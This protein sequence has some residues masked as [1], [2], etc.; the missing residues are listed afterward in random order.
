VNVIPDQRAV[1][2][3]V[4]KRTLAETEAPASQVQDTDKRYLFFIA[5][6]AGYSLAEQEGPPPRRGDRIEIPGQ[7]TSFLVVKLGPSP[8][9]NDRRSCAYLEPTAEITTWVAV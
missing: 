9:P 7:A 8:L 6:P 5:T 4:S 1:V 2:L 3:K